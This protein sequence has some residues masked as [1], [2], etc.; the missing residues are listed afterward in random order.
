MSLA[1]TE[2]APAEM[3][4]PPRAGS[5]RSFIGSRWLRIALAV[6]VLAVLYAL[7]RLNPR[8]LLAGPLRWGW[9][10]LALALFLPNYLLGAL[11]YH[12]VLRG[13]GVNCTFGQTWR[14]TMYAALGELILPPTG[15]SDVVRAVAATRAAATGRVRGLASA[16]ADRSV[17]LCGLTVFALLACALDRDAVLCDPRLAR[18]PL[19]ALVCF[20]VCAGSV[21]AL[22]ALRQLVPFGVKS[23]IAGIS[24]G[25]CGMRLLGTVA[26][27]YRR[28]PQVLAAVCFAAGGHCLWCL[29]AVALAYGLDLRVPFLT[30]LV[31]FPLVILANTVSFAGGIGGGLI[32]IE[33]LFEVLFGVPRGMGL[34][35]GLALPLATNLSRLIAL[36]WFFARRYRAPTCLSHAGSGDPSCRQAA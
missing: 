14:I 10:A 23:R 28:L 6:S 8:D 27:F 5:L 30:A 34:K 26:A 21:V 3:T 33:L 7:G 18:T 24:W 17:G 20:T 1:N 12:I 11:R 15:A 22:L 4:P 32:V 36:P 25:A 16:L 9:I 19:L 35:L 13:M 29:S 31:V 2:R